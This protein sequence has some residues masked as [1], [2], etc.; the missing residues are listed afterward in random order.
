MAA[1]VSVPDRLVHLSTHHHPLSGRKWMNRI[2]P[3][4]WMVYGLVVDQLGD[5][6][7]VA[8]SGVEVGSEVGWR[9]RA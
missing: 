1:A 6:T 2:S 3:E 7:G 4:T 5:R 9:C 8:V